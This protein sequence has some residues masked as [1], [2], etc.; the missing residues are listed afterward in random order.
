MSIEVKLSIAD[1]PNVPE[2]SCPH[3]GL[4]MDCA[5][6]V[7]GA[8]KPKPG[9]LG[10]CIGCGEFSLYGETLQLVKIDPMELLKLQLDPEHGPVLKRL[11]EAWVATKFTAKVSAFLSGRIQPK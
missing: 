6:G 5:S 11:H 4:V 7:N 8:R 1:G 9:N 3:C 2:S 10:M